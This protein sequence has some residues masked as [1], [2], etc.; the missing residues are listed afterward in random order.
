MQGICLDDKICWKLDNKITC[1]IHVIYMLYFYFFRFGIWW[2][3]AEFG[4][5]DRM[6]RR[7]SSLIHARHLGIQRRKPSFLSRIFHKR[8]LQN[9]KRSLSTHHPTSEAAFDSV[10]GCTRIPC[11]F[12]HASTAFRFVESCLVFLWSMI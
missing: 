9:Q 4:P 8:S 6:T 3:Y 1:L 10:D 11:D 5:A 7:S 12:S 2:T